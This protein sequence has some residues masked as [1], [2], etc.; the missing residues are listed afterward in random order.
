MSTLDSNER[1]AHIIETEEGQ[2]LRKNSCTGADSTTLAN[3]AAVKKFLVSRP[4]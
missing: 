1:E 2:I 4:V 3:L